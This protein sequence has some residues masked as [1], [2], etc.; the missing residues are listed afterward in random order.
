MPAPTVFI[1]YSQD[2]SE[3]AERVRGLGASLARDGFE[4]RMDTYKETDEQWP[5]WMSRQLVE[6]DFVLC[7]VTETYERR[8]RDNE[9]PDVG[10]G[11]GWEASLIRRLLYGKKLRND[12]IF[13]VVF[14]KDDRDR[15]PLELQGYDFFLLDGPDGYEA[16]L[17][18][19]QKRPLH[20]APDVGVGPLL[21]TTTTAP[22][23]ARPGIAVV[24]YSAPA[25]PTDISRIL[26][27]A[28][29]E[30]LERPHRL[31]L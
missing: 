2:S 7:V 10:L 18:K 5:T 26:K 20:A 13:P 21:V 29:A 6:A 15:I 31:D 17:R 11:V 22:L 16:L 3:H 30:L 14:A 25:L 8:F 28:P 27:S 4:G 24:A 12:R 1:S 9:L 23:F 19:L